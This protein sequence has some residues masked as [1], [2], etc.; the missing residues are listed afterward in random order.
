MNARSE[1]DCHDNSHDSRQDN[2][3]DNGDENSG[4][5]ESDPSAQKTGRSGSNRRFPLQLLSSLGVLALA[6]AVVAYFMLTG[7]P[8]PRGEP[9]LRAVLVDVIDVEARA[10]RPSIDAHGSLQPA[11]RL[12][13]PAQVG[14]RVVTVNPALELGGMVAAGETLVQIEKADFEL[15]ARQASSRL[16]EARAE[17]EL[18]QGR[19]AFARQELE[20]FE[21]FEAPVEAPDKLGLI[22]REPQLRRIRA[23]IERAQADLDLAR[24]NLE[25]AT[26]VAPFDSII[27]AEDIEIGQVLQPGTPVAEL[28]GTQSARVVVR[29]EARHLPHLEIPGWNA[30]TGSAGTVRYR[31]GEAEVSRPIRIRHLAGSL[32]E[33][34]R[35]ARL[36]CELDDPL[37]LDRPSDEIADADAD[38][39]T[40]RSMLFGAFVDVEL[41]MARERDLFEVPAGAMR[42]R[43]RLFVMTSDGTLSI[44][45]P[46]VFLRSGE[47]VYL[48]DGLAPGDRVITSLIANP[49]EGMK[50]RTAAPES[51][52]G[53][54]GRQR[55]ER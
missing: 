11:R 6:I 32:G 8:A 30:E 54:S 36:L 22:L 4:G 13:L 49:V 10:V 7:Q 25:R 46:T 14:G 5:N 40:M 45:E 52:A 17:L 51:D 19:Q 15:A 28:L 43:D 31:L 53:A 18:E 24:L 12:Q 50:L 21:N 1:H 9:A 3:Q 37:G 16:Q 27:E 34:G 42:N 29:V 38:A 47:R 39:D 48:S 44:R 20:S 23:T 41:E 55:S 35:M 26:I 2:G 33:T